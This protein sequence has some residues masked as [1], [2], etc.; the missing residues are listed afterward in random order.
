M[1]VSEMLDRVR[2]SLSDTNKSRYSD[3]R[4]IILLND[5]INDISRNTTLFIENKIIPIL[6][7]VVEYDW[8]DFVS[9]LVY[10][11]Y[12][13]RRLPIKTTQ[14]L[15]AMEDGWRLETG[16]RLKALVYNIHKNGLFYT[17]PRVIDAENITLNYSSPYGIITDIQVIDTTPD[18]DT[19]NPYGDIVLYECVKIYYIRKHEEVTSLNDVLIVDP[20]C[21]DIIE[22]FIC[23][24]VLLDNQDVQNIN[25]SSKKLSLYST[26]ME[27]Y[28]LARFEGFVK[29]G[30]EVAYNPYGG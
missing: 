9:S 10:A 25:L 13:G 17:Y 26:M 30:V 29:R 11:E 16:T 20:R 2:Y 12:G 22:H 7:N 4:L 6:N 18:I 8:S 21:Y 27:S 23:G 28:S 3:E 15:D 19:E 14:E 5:A 24:M 1:I